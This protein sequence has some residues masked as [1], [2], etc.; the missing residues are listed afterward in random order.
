MLERVDDL[1]YDL[2]E[3]IAFIAI[4]ARMRVVYRASVYNAT[5]LQ[6]TRFERGL[7]GER[8]PHVGMSVLVPFSTTGLDSHG[9]AW[10]R[11]PGSVA[12]VPLND[13]EAASSYRFDVSS[14]GLLQP[15]AADMA[16]RDANG[17]R[18]RGD[19]AVTGYAQA[20]YE[21]LLR[22][23]VHYQATEIQRVLRGA[24]TRRWNRQ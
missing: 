5:V 11:F 16:V 6:N 8:H 21:R 18:I 14:A 13:C 7:K 4:A 9:L 22:A 24:I 23:V 12:L 20:K 1:A 3:R 17:V 15:T 19:E 10:S 2:R